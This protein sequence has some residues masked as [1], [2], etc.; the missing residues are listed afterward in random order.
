MGFPN[1][2]KPNDHDGD[3][4][5]NLQRRDRELR[6]MGSGSDDPTPSRSPRSTEPE[7]KSEAWYKRR[8]REANDDFKN[9]K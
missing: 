4:E 5:S 6:Q 8:E 2:R 7:Y 9:A 1:V 3:E